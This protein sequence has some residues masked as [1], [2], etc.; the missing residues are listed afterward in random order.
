MEV[1]EGEG[2]LYMRYERGMRR[3][4]DLICLDVAWSFEVEKGEEGRNVRTC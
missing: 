2:V 1:V 4:C 3:A